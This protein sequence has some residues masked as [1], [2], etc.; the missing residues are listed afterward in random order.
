MNLPE[1][2]KAGALPKEL[3][4]EDKWLLTRFNN[5]AK[6][7]TDNIDSYELGVAVQKIRDFIWEIYCDW[8]IELTKP[9]ISEGGEK[10]LNAQ[11]Y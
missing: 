3:T 8:Y 4:I 11:K 6:E 7:V 5:L 1:G 9:R 10:A 2:F